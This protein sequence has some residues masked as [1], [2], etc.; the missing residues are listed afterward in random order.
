MLATPFVWGPTPL[1]EDA[2]P[3]DGGAGDAIVLTVVTR[4]WGEDR[5][6]RTGGGRVDA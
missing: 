5:G 6:G 4:W 1:G 2:W 3:N